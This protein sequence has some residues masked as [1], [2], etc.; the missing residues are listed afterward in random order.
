MI[1]SQNRLLSLCLHLFE[2]VD[3]LMFQLVVCNNDRVSLGRG[4]HHDPLEIGFYARGC[5]V[6]SN[7]RQM[8]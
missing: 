5:V 7:G 4:D 6:D 2:E 1:M 3:T 8:F